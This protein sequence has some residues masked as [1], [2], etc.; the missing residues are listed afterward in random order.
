MNAFLLKIFGKVPFMQAL[1]T[2]YPNLLLCPYVFGLLAMLL[3]M[4]GFMIAL[5]QIGFWQPIYYST[6][7]RRPVDERARAELER[8]RKLSLEYDSWRVSQKKR[9][10]ALDEREAQ[11]HREQNSLKLEK[12]TLDKI[13]TEIQTMRAELDARILLIDTSQDTNLQQLAKLYSAM[14]AEAA[15]SLL[16]PMDEK[17]IAQ[18]LRKMKET[19]SSKILEVWAKP[20]TAEKAKRVTSWMQV[21][22]VP[23]TEEAKP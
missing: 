11:L 20:A 13:R 2:K 1:L 18:I 14:T 4:T 22:V 19:K 17:Q 23:P 10:E 3:F 15:A 16:A 12:Q 9:E 6:A 5:S 8:L 21:T 7:D